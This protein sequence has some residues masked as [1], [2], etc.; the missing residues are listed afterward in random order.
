MRA[1]V[2]CAMALVLAAATTV[3]ATSPKVQAPRMSAELTQALWHQPQQQAQADSSSSSDGSSGGLKDDAIIAGPFHVYYDL[4]RAR[5]AEAYAGCEQFGGDVRRRHEC[6]AAVA[7]P[8]AA[9]VA[10]VR[11]W[12]EPLGVAGSMGAA[13]CHYAWNAVHCREV[14]AGAVRRVFGAAAAPFR[15]YQRRVGGAKVVA[16]DRYQ[17]TE[18]ALVIP[19]SVAGAVSHVSGLQPFN[20][21]QLSG[22]HMGATVPPS[23]RLASPMGTPQARRRRTLGVR[24]RFLVHTVAAQ[25]FPDPRG[26]CGAA[27][28][29]LEQPH[30]DLRAAL[31]KRQPQRR[32]PILSA[33]EH[34]PLGQLLS[35][36]PWSYKRAGGEHPRH[37]RRRLCAALHCPGCLQLLPPGQY[38]AA[39]WRDVAVRRHLCG[40]PLCVGSGAEQ[41]D[42][43]RRVP[44]D[45]HG[46]VLQRVCDRPCSG[47]LQR[48]NVRSGRS[49]SFHR[50]T[51][52]QAPATPTI[53]MPS[54]NMVTAGDD[55]QPVQHP[56][57]CQ[58]D[59]PGAGRGGAY[60]REPAA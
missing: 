10:A 33:H 2:L 35:Q 28:L 13:G 3:D 30:R 16:G 27:G 7:G 31:R 32:E 56:G 50:A 46:A 60:R 22:K 24:G 53:T 55:L 29:A 6:R 15:T 51:V 11:A 43:V 45:C 23:V 57:G 25:W 9:E 14:R 17:F 39:G 44:D 40:G 41:R 20:H 38:D 59:G 34:Q 21:V 12:L 5:A 42:A 58:R 52:G 36:R 54:P 49:E 8:S 47:L 26:R 48:H 4:Q 19:A 1:L 18:A 37:V